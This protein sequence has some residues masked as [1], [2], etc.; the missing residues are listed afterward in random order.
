MKADLTILRRD[1]EFY[2]KFKKK[3]ASA[4][5]NIDFK[6]DALFRFLLNL[7]PYIILVL[8]IFQDFYLFLYFSV[9]Y[10]FI[11]SDFYRKL[12]TSKFI[13]SLRTILLCK[14]HQK[15]GTTANLL[16]GMTREFTL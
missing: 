3:R 13:F 16:T 6:A 8:K 10:A 7:Y 12:L 2:K 9:L 5:E 4:F 15:Y 14:L 11:K 1:S